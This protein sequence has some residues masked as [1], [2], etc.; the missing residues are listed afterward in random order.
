MKKT[1][2]SNKMVSTAIVSLVFGVVLSTM[3]AAH[4]QP[5]G[6]APAP[7]PTPTPE[8]AVERN[9]IDIETVERESAAGPVVEVILLRDGQEERFI[10]PNLSYLEKDKVIDYGKL[11][12]DDVQVLESVHFQDGAVAVELHVNGIP[13][14]IASQSGAT[15]MEVSDVFKFVDR[16]SFLNSNNIKE[17]DT[18]SHFFMDSNNFAGLA[19]LEDGQGIKFMGA[20]T[21][22]NVIN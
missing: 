12:M 13:V 19:I 7:Q 5:V 9:Y 4:A 2:K 1:K 17:P 22:V 8:P 6:G 16:A 18:V 15:I 11:H 3:R 20:K 10:T 14:K 21:S